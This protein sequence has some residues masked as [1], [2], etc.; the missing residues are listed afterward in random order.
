MTEYRAH[1]TAGIGIS[2][3]CE[4]F[5]THASE[6]ETWTMTVQ[7]E[8]KLDRTKITVVRRI[9]G[10]TLEHKRNTHSSRELL[11]LEPVSLASTK[12]VD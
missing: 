8:A 2:Q 7:H 10:F 1:R 11:R 4:M 9:C 5:L 3:F 12:F 6:T